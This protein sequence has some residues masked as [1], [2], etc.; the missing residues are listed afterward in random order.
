V[1]FLASTQIGNGPHLLTGER[2]AAQDRFRSVVDWAIYAEELGFDAVGVGERHLSPFLSSSPPVVLSFLA[3]RTTRVRLLTTVTMLSLLDPVR[4]AEDYA[5]LDQ[6]SGGRVELIIG[7][8]DDPHQAALFG[9]TIDDQGERN[10][11]NYELLRRLWREE[12]VT[13]EG[14]FRPPLRAATTQP[15]PLQPTIPIWHGS[16]A[17]EESTDLAARWGDPLFSANGFHPLETYARLVRH[18]RERWQAYGR[19][20]ADAVVGAGCGAVYVARTS[21]EALGTFRPYFHAYLRTAAARQHQ[22]P[23]TSVEDVIARGPA[24]VGSPQQVLEKVHHVHEA[25]GHEILGI[26]V[27][28]FGIPVPHQ[29]ASLELFFAEVAPLL[30]RALPSRMWS[31]RQPP[32]LP[33]AAVRRS[34]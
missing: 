9:T 18:Y 2:T 6:L 33:R 16:A 11:E 30:R 34:A 13:W 17:S 21:Q 4:V 20:P 8:G 15:R 22:P 31:P 29:R 23:F 5:T 26:G 25:F 10:R 19:D 3:A 14:K 32:L 12:N 27:D 28:G 1:K 7:S 24:L